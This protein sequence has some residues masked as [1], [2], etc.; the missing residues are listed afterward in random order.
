MKEIETADAPHHTGP[1]PQAV[2]QPDHLGGFGGQPA[3]VGGPPAPVQQAAGDVVEHGQAVQQEELLE[4]KPEPPGPQ[5]RQLLI[6]HD[7]GVLPGDADHAVR[8]PLQRAHHMKQR[9]LA[10]PRRAHDRG[11][12]PLDDPQIHPAQ[13]HHRRIAGILLYDARQ[14][15]DRRRRRGRPGRERE[16]LGHDDD[17]STR[18]PAMSP[19]PLTW[20]RV[21]P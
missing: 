9:A 12:L 13:G 20:T 21:L 18:V 6:R 2:T 19:G 16:R 8:R 3:P 11:Q 1:V 4:H 14:L 15:Q 10:R 17:T 5:P 7:R